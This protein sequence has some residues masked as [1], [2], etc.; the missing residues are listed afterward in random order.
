MARDLE[1]TLVTALQQAVLRPAILVSIDSSAGIVRVWSGKGTLAWPASPAV[2]WTGLGELGGISSIDETRDVQAKGIKLTLSGIPTDMVSLALSDAEPGR[3]VNVYLAMFDAS[4]VIITDPYLAFSGSTDAINLVEGGDTSTI[5][6]S[7]ES[8]L[9]RLQ[10]AN[11]SRFTHDDQQI[12]FSGD[13]GF[14]FVEQLQELSIP[15]GPQEQGVPTGQK[16]V[17]RRR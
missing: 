12:R 9:I 7:V 1:L 2:N 5:E 15:F 16:L 17:S 10:R 4:G 14:E 13:L 11:E 8:E 6:V 3:E